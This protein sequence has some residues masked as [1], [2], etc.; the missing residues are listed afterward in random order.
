MGDTL[1]LIFPVFLISLFL[2]G[3]PVC[4]FVFSLGRKTKE[5]H[6]ISHFQVWF[7]FSTLVW[8]LN[9]YLYYY[10]HFYYCR[11]YGVNICGSS[12]SQDNSNDEMITIIVTAHH[13]MLAF[14]ILHCFFSPFFFKQR[15]LARTFL[16]HYLTSKF[17]KE[18]C[19]LFA[20]TI[21][22]DNWLADF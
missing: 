3:W 15:L 17:F 22:W 5:I 1:A 21:M 13:F 18:F 20:N 11:C 12:F 10:H 9:Y 16:S 4:C 2:P 8:V 6:I 19:I 14:C 7:G